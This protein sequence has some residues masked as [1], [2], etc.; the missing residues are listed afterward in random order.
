MAKQTLKSLLGLSDKREQVELNL[1]DQVFNAPSVQ[2]G[3]YTVA[4]PRYTTSNTASQLSNALGKYAGPIARGLGNIEQERQEQFADLAASTPTEILQ[5]IQKGD[6]DPVK[7][8]FDEFSGKLDQAERKKLIKFSENPNNYIR[9]SRVLGDRLAQQYQA[10]LRERRDDY[11]SKRDENGDYIPARDQMNTIADQLIQDN[12]LS[13]YALRAFNES[14]LKFEAQEEL[15]INQRQDE[16]FQGEVDHNTKTNLIAAIGNENLDDFAQ[17]FQLGTNNK[18]VPEQTDMLKDIVSK[19]AELDIAS[20][21]AFVKKLEQDEGFLTIGSGSELGDSLLNDLNDTLE[22]QESVN[23]QREEADINNTKKD[24]ANII[25]SSSESLKQ[26]QPL[27]EVELP[28]IDSDETVTVDLS[29]VKTTEELYT[30]IKEQYVNSNPDA[31]T[32]ATILSGLSQDIT[33]LQNAESD[34]YQKTGLDKIEA[35][36]TTAYAESI[37]GVNLYGLNDTEITSKVSSLTQELE[38][39]LK[40]IYN[41]PTL[42]NVQ[43]QE[44]ATLAVAKQSRAIAEQQRQDADT[45]ITT[46]QTGKFYTSVGLS[47]TNNNVS[48]TLVRQ[49]TANDELTGMSIYSTSQAL[50]MTKPFVAE[51]REGVDNILNAP[52]TDAERSSGNMV[53]VIQNREIAARDYLDQSMAQFIDEKFD[54]PSDDIVQ[55]RIKTQ[56]E[57]EAE[58]ITPEIQERFGDPK[59]QTMY[60]DPYSDAV[61]VGDIMY[62]PEGEVGT[63][64]FPAGAG[65]AGYAERIKNRRYLLKDLRKADLNKLR[66]EAT[67]PPASEFGFREKALQS[68]RRQKYFSVLAT[69]R[70]LDN[71]QPIVTIEEIRDGKLEGKVPINV[72]NL[73]FTRNP[74]ISY[75]MIQESQDYEEEITAYM[76]V[77][78]LDPNNTVLRQRF[79]KAQAIAHSQVLKR[80]FKY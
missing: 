80:V 76:V 42:S 38:V 66:T 39:E 33:T 72:E 27:G 48:Q 21:S 26:G 31:T 8:Q 4:S 51:L 30:T 62:H 10:D 74:I 44:Q 59:K 11:A 34:F 14:R 19:A 70:S 5:A 73:D 64:Q 63:S 35:E 6:L 55:E 77:L 17:Q 41:D 56:Q 61:T 49:L 32:R 36:L 23:R 25:L 20:A 16:Y 1:D 24:L 60:K 47:A 3:R 57:R 45:F 53:A 78:N 65:D 18:T 13:G 79:L 7:E 40:R 69:Q 28:L 58:A 50:E 2:A 9:A 22:A 52:L 75:D 12:N 71:D 29:K 37:E 67:K 54:N 43:K 15:Y 46:R 68:H